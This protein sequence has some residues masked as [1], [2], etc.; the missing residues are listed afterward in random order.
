MWENNKKYV[1]KTIYVEKK[2]IQRLLKT[3]IEI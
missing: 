2:K 3:Y 1:I